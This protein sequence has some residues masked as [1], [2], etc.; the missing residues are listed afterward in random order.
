MNREEAIH[1]A[2]LLAFRENRPQAL[3]ECEPGV[4]CVA[5]MTNDPDAVW[6]YPT[7][8]VVKYAAGF[9]DDPIFDDTIPE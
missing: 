1:A 8:A 2:K 7:D 6:I 9:R 4:Y 3:V 5:I